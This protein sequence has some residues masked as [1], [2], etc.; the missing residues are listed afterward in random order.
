MKLALRPVGKNAP[1][2]PRRFDWMSWSVTSCGFIARA[3]SSWAYPPTARYD[4]RSV[5][6]C[7]IAPSRTTTG[8]SK[9]I[10]VSAIGPELRD[11]R[12]HVLGR[13]RLP[14]A[15]IDRDDRRRRA[16]AQ[17]LH[18]AQR[19]SPVRRRLARPDPEL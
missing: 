2:R 6:G 14:V 12:R 5:S 19:D 7:S 16:A 8:G 10:V 13:D 3:R 9:P 11:D 1:P 15:V 4:A 17:A 18:G